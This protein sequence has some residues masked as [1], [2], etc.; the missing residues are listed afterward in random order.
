[1]SHQRYRDEILPESLVERG[2]SLSRELACS[3]MLSGAKRPQIL[4]GSVL[5]SRYAPLRPGAALWTRHGLH[6]PCAPILARQTG[7]ASSAWIPFSHALQVARS[8][9]GFSSSCVLPTRSTPFSMAL[10]PH[11]LSARFRSL[12]LL[13]SPFSGARLY[14]VQRYRCGNEQEE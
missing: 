5:C 9:P 6:S 12:R 8:T 1:M 13:T 14:P 7:L 2:V 10:E 11:T 4:A 3:G